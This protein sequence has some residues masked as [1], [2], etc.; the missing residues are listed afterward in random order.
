MNPEKL[1]SRCRSNAWGTFR[2]KKVAL[3]VILYLTLTVEG[4]EDDDLYSTATDFVKPLNA[5]TFETQVIKSQPNLIWVVE[6]YN[7]WCGHCMHFAPTWKKLAEYMKEWTDLVVIAAIDCSQPENM[8]PCRRFDI[9]SFPTMKMFPPTSVIDRLGKVELI[10]TQSLPEIK[11]AILDFMTTFAPETWPR[12]KHLD[13]MQDLWHEKNIY[14]SELFIIF[15]D[16]DSQ[17]GKMVVLDLRN[18]TGIKVFMMLRNK[19]TKFGITEFPSLYKFNPDSTYSKLAVG[20]NS[21]ESDRLLFV[22]R[23]K[24]DVKTTQANSLSVGSDK[25]QK[26]PSAV[27]RISG[28]ISMDS[29]E[30]TSHSNRSDL[31]SA[32]HYSLRQEVAICQTIDG[33][34]LGALK[35]YINVL[36]KYFPGREPVQLF[37]VEVWKMLSN[38]QSPALTGE[39]WMNNLDSLQAESHYLPEVIRWASCEGSSPQ[40][41]G[42][43]CSMWTL[44]HTLTVGAHA[45]SQGRTPGDAKEVLL[46]IRGYMKHFFGCGECSKH[47]LEMSEGVESE[48]TSHTE[49]VLWLWRRHNQV[50]KRLHGHESEDPRFPKVQ[51]PPRSVCPQCK[52]PNGMKWDEEKVFAFLVGFYSGAGIFVPASLQSFKEGNQRDGVDSLE[53]SIGLGNKVKQLDWWEKKQRNRDLRVVRELRLRKQKK[54]SPN[55]AVALQHLSAEKSQVDEAQMV[56]ERANNIRSLW[57]VTNIDLSMCVVFYVISTVIILLLY[58]HFIIRRHRHPCR[59]AKTKSLSG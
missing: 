21:L 57:G 46:A 40:F 55:R 14:K 47:F 4:F 41:R 45:Q 8:L 37:L 39:E 19:V 23:I 50:N 34:R 59:A 54:N 52:S 33:E 5:I 44:F 43:P 48:V 18:V 51:F 11:T 1:R 17:I 20:N 7:R 30:Q 42:F 9:Q 31:E 53:D 38:L 12:L 22:Q 25:D 6:F 15:E 3:V 2:L 28:A 36:K 10:K 16:E 13:E 49:A 58:H 27:N 24:E 35:E 26:D 32:L 56:K 29:K